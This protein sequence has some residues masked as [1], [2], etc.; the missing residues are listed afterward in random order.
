MNPRAQPCAFCREDIPWRAARCPRCDERQPVPRA[1]GREL[2]AMLL[3]GA[4]LGLLAIATTLRL[5]AGPLNLSAEA[6]ESLRFLEL[7][8]VGCILLLLAV[9]LRQG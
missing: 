9:I 8:V 3:V 4:A 1:S 5:T 7:A 6:V 2:L